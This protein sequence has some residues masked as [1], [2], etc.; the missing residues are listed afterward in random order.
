MPPQA[1]EEKRRFERGKQWAKARRKAKR[2][3]K[4]EP[5]DGITGHQVP[6]PGSKPD[7]KTKERVIRAWKEKQAKRKAETEPTDGITGQ[8]I[9]LPRRLPDKAKKTEPA[10]ESGA[11][12]GSYALTAASKA[13]K[14]KG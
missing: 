10:V 1:E 9:P 13:P 11:A 6:L 7:E 4:T 12:F 3:T 14:A 8:P 5:T 2:K